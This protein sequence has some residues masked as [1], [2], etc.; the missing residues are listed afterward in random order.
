[1]GEDLAGSYILFSGKF[2]NGGWG[3]D[4]SAQNFADLGTG[5]DVI[6]FDSGNISLTYFGS[7]IG[8]F[9][10]FSTTS[11]YKKLNLKISRA[12][13]NNSDLNLNYNICHATNV[14]N[15]SDDYTA[16]V[17]DWDYTGVVVLDTNVSKLSDTF[18][19][20]TAYDSTKFASNYMKDFR[21]FISNAFVYKP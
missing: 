19:V 3:G 7:D 1:V 17:F 2:T 20:S 11:M 6:E 8:T 9:Y 13:P 21:N 4:C 18:I 5:L 15:G 14:W 12:S 16:S 10:D